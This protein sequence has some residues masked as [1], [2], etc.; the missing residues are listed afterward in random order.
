MNAHKTKNRGSNNWISQQQGEIVENYKVRG[1]ID[2]PGTPK[3][4]ECMMK[5][6]RLLTS[7][8]ISTTTIAKAVQM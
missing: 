8:G 3:L 1:L 4:T 2:S 5:N 6:M 7:E